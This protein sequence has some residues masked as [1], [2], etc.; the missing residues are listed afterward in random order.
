[1]VKV[2]G[3][4]MS[5]GASGK[6]GGALVFSKWK[7]RPYVRTLVRPANPKSG[8]QVG[9]R[10][11]FKF[12]SQKWAGLTAGNKAT[13]EDYADQLVVSPFNA[14]MGRNQFRYRDF[15]P[16]TKEDPAAEVEVADAPC[17]LVTT[18]G[19]RSISIELTPAAWVLDWGFAIFRDTA[20][21]VTASFDN[22][23]GIVLNDGANAV[24]WLDTPLEP[25]DY[26][27]IA[28]G[29]SNDGVWGGDSNEDTETVV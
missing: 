19:I 28:K 6:L 16:P 15:T 8:G 13:W 17:V 29:F 21:A 7:G 27:Y 4:M 11:M 2:E 18:L 1:M 3:P 5:L 14:F 12:L 25:N 9:V 22:L 10:A 26:H 24:T 20:P 23:I